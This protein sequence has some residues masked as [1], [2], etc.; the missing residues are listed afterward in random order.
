[1][2]SMLRRAML[3]AEPTPACAVESDAIAASCT[4]ARSSSTQHTTVLKAK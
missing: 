4:Q 3:E 1:V 2:R